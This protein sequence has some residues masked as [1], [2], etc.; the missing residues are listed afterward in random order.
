VAK[1]RATAASDH[2]AEP[3]AG[4]GTAPDQLPALSSVPAE[5]LDV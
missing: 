2:P 5:R 3:S 1:E 4:D